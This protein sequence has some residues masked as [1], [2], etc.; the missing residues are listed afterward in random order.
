MGMSKVTMIKD[1]MAMDE[2]LDLFS[3]DL[4]FEIAE[5]QIQEALRKVIAQAK[6]AG[7]HDSFHVF[8][9]SGHRMLDM[10]T[11]NI[12]PELEKR[13]Y[14]TLWNNGRMCHLKNEY[15]DWHDPAEV[16]TEYRS[17]CMASLA[18]GNNFYDLH[19]IY[20]WC[21]GP[22]I[23]EAVQAVKIQIAEQLGLAHAKEKPNALGLKM[24]LVGFGA[25][26]ETKQR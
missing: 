23:E 4:H 10:S 5:D 25:T 13:G 21:T 3:L 12:L 11:T 17:R 20:L 6:K 24:N 9:S 19:N 18:G 14:L 7:N 22:G 15:K 1:S 2:Q 8:N 26:I 16:A